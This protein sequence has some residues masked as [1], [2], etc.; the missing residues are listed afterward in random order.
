M[1]QGDWGGGGAPGG[2]GSGGPPPGGGGYDPPPG[3]G[4]GPPSGGGYGP[5]GSGRQET[6]FFT[7]NSVTITN[8]RAI[9]HGTTYALANVTSVRPWIVKKSTTPLLL[10][11][12]SL[13][14]GLGVAFGS[15]GC[16]GVVLLLGAV[17]LLVYFTS[18]DRYFVRI[19]T[20]GG[21]VDALVS[22]SFAYVN[23]IVT[24]LNNAIIHRG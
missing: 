6:P 16:G 17:C 20:A 19:G 11:I 3:G 7:D 23:Q 24:A 18:K 9:I 13:L 2:W 10:G 22:T 21:E 8:A 1:S 4:Y 15:A 5:P 14:A 12:L